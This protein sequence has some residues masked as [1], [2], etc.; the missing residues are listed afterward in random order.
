M[1]VV[2]R[3]DSS[4]SMG[5]GHLM[6][7][8]ALAEG[9]RTHGATVTFICRELTGNLI[10][11]AERKGISVKV[12]SAPSD[13][14]I[15]CSAI[16]N[17]WFG[18]SSSQDARDTIDAID[19]EIPDWL[20]I[21]HYSIDFSWENLIRPYCRKIMV[22]DD[23][24]NRKHNCDLLLD[25]NY[26]IHSAKRYDMLVPHSCIVLIGSSYALLRAEFEVLRSHSVGKIG[27]VKKILIF[28][29]AGNDQGET[30][31]AMQGICNF[32]N[33]ER[34]DVVIGDSNP[35]LE[36]IREICIA[37]NWGY[38]CQVDYIAELMAGVDLVIGS[39]GS[40]SWERCAL[41]IPAITSILAENQA[42]IAQALD[43]AGAIINLGLNTDLN[44][45]SYADALNLVT[46]EKLASLSAAAFKLV[47]A[48]GVS[49]VTEILLSEQSA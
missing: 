14:S 8:I 2:F 20:I 25:Q 49:R 4:T 35:N 32:E 21:D 5:S 29:T 15:E 19:G 16:N 39:S 3:V 23:L 46:T 6:R 10:L 22:I 42:E 36:I 45:S 24:A 40:S 18:V 7:C 38:H 41:G 43:N 48:K 17:Y 44:A 33:I 12:L 26:Y 47:D 9:L 34:V 1:K 27:P 11:I 31:K 37:N 28:F 30:L 13:N